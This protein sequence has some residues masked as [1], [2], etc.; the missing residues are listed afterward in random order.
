MIICIGVSV[1]ISPLFTYPKH[2]N[3]HICNQNPISNLNIWLLAAVKLHYTCH[4]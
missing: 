1:V 2:T 3:E 4:A